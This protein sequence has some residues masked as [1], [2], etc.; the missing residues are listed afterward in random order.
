MLCEC[1]PVAT[2]V[3]GS[4]RAVGETGF[5]VPPDDPSALADAL[6]RALIVP[7]EQGRSSRERIIHMFTEGK[8]DTR[9]RQLIE[10]EGPSSADSR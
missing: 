2:D 7:D 3:G 9:L 10:E 1:I 6:L 5:L 4:R 8:R